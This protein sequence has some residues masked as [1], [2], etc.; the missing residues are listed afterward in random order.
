MTRFLNVAPRLPV[1][2]L[3]RAIEYYTDVLKFT[4]CRLWPEESPAFAILE[5][6]DVCVQ[7]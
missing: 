1:T 7:F 3:R 5:R 2:D 4:A 6:D